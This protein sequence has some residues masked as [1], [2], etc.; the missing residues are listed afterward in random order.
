M[1]KLLKILGSIKQDVDFQKEEGLFQKGI[2]SS[3][4]MVYLVVGIKNEFGIEIDPEDITI[5][6]FDSAQRIMKLIERYKGK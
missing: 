2:F 6:N 1:E 5:E 4:D 3:L